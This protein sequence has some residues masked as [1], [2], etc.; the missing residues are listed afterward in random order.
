MLMTAHRV[1]SSVYWTARA[2]GAEAAVA[3]LN[4]VFWTF[5]LVYVLGVVNVYPLCRAAKRD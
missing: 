3:A 1:W 5:N 2:G 4:V